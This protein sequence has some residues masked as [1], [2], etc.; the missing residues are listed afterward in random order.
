LEERNWIDTFMSR[1]LL[2]AN[3]TLV[4]GSFAILVSVSLIHAM[5][6]LM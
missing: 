4:S 3:W 6:S 1:T 5:A 2:A